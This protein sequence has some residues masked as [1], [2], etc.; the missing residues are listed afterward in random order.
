MGNPVWGPQEGESAAE[1]AAFVLWRASETATPRHKLAKSQ[2]WADR[3]QAWLEACGGVLA[4]SQE[5]RDKTTLDALHVAKTLAQ[6][7]LSKH[8]AAALQN[9]YPSTSAKD[10]VRILKDA[11]I[12]ERL[13]GG[14]STENVDV[15]DYAK[16]S[17][18]DLAML[19]ELDEKAKGVAK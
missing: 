13:V 4:M 1:Y 14:L 17:D 18:K 3:K 8:L 2:F 10:A 7:D 11:T 5:A 12:L 19:L 16:L 6:A 15:R 9:S